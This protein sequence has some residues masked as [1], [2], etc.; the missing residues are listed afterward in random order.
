M[1]I[2]HQLIRAVEGRL[3]HLA[4]KHIILHT[5]LENRDAQKL[6]LKNG[7]QVVAMKKAF[8]PSGQDAMLMVKE[9]S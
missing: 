3:G 5:A 8:Y 4:E 9:I 2:G 1:G 7:Y 6:F